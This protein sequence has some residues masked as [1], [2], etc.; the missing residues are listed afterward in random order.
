MK[1]K[2]LA[3]VCGAKLEG[4][5]EREINDVAKPD[6]AKPDQVCFIAHKKYLPLLEKSKPGAVIAGAGMSIPQ[7]TPV[8]R[9]ADADLAFSK[10]VTALRGEMIRPLPG[11]ADHTV[12]GGDFQMGENSSVGPFCVLGSDVKLGKNVIVYPHCYIGDGV[13][14]GDDT[15]L[16]PRV[17]I[18]ERCKL[19]NR[20]IIHSGAVI[21]A[22]GF[23]FHFNAGKFEKAPQRGTVEL[24]DDVEVGAN[25]TVDRARFDVTRLKRGTKLDNLVQIGHNVEVG[26]HCVIAASAAVGGSAV[27]KDYVQ[28]GGGSGIAD[29]LTIGMGARIA[30]M[31]GVMQSVDP[32]MKMAGLPADEGR[33]FM[34]REAAVRKLPEMM[35]EFR[36]LKATVEKLVGHAKFEP[37][38]DDEERN[39]EQQPEPGE[40]TRFIRNRPKPE[41]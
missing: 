7:G 4:D 11:I 30:A 9:V 21:G 25:S 23:G 39:D 16:Y 28:L 36:E 17:T 26:Q 13:T 24:E 10:A 41:E 18:M 5:G 12:I 1:L 34:K 27:L 3:Q 38:D 40:F 29:H 6:A 22:D 20:N 31:T 19:G 8:L 32:G 33:A 35:A 14:I 2:D 37:V 15:I